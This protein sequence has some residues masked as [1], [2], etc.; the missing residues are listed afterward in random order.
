MI[1]SGYKMK[2]IK[3]TG[4]RV[5]TEIIYLCT[6]LCLA[7][8]LNIHAI[9]KFDSPWSELFTQLPVVILVSLVIYVLILLARFIIMGAV[10][11]FHHSKK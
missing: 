3:I 2:D 10:R 11:L 6:S 1:N 4:K 8:L 5:K 7:I 9:N